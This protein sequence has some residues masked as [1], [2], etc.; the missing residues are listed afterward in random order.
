MPEIDKQQMTE[1]S[2]DTAPK[3]AMVAITLHG[4]TL[5]KDLARQYIQADI[6]LTEKFIYRADEFPA[7]NKPIMIDAPIRQVMG[8]L[9][10]SYD[11][12]VL[13]FSIGAA[14]RLMAP[15]L[16]SKREDP[17]VVVI[18]DCGQ[19][20][21]PVLSGHI[22]GANAFAGDIAELIDATAV[23]TTASES[24]QTLPV[25]ILGRELGWVV[26]APLHNQVKVA[27]HVVN[28]EPIAF[29]Q[30]AGSRQWWPEDK[31]LPDNIHLFN[32]FD[33]VD[34][35]Q[36]S[37]VLWVTH[38]DISESLWQQLDGRL[39]VYRPPQ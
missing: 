38:Q 29:V 15:Y 25:D 37:A 2:E 36:F 17:G 39:I 3:I 18:D 1:K 16:K 20:V 7:D 24:R 35:Q 28:D 34:I 8:T 33:A 9:F 19:F 12:L 22:G 23:Y 6:F 13:V 5:L 30:E 11:L 4:S 31:K 26:E 14:V 21:I 27:A 10:E 32:S